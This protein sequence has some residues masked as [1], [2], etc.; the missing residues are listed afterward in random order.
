MQWICRCAW[1]NVH[2]H[3]GGRRS[4][5]RESCPWDYIPCYVAVNGSSH[6]QTGDIGCCDVKNCGTHSYSC[7]PLS[8]LGRVQCVQAAAMV[9]AAKWTSVLVW[10]M[11]SLTWLRLCRWYMSCLSHK[12]TKGDAVHA[13]QVLCQCRRQGRS[14]WP[15]LLCRG[16]CRHVDIC[17]WGYGH[18]ETGMAWQW[19]EEIVKVCFA[20]D[21]VCS[22]KRQFVGSASKNAIGIIRVEVLRYWLNHL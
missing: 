16:S 6:G 21:G 15:T 5:G 22:S 12:S 14:L 17:Q 7:L 2:L 19:G 10:Q 13:M 20:C 8:T 1:L 9:R 11:P 3:H 4:C 18:L